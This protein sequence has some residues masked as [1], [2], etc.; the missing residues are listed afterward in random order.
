MKKLNS[1]NWDRIVRLLA[2][3]KHCILAVLCVPCVLHAQTTSDIEFQYLNI[4]QGLSDNWVTSIFMDS[5]GFMWIGTNNGLNRWDGVEIKVF[6]NNLVN[7]N[8]LVDNTINCIYED[9]QGRIWI[10]TID[11]INVFDWKTEKFS[12]FKSN[13]NDTASLGGKNVIKI[14]E[15][16][17]KNMWV[18]TTSG[19]DMFDEQSHTFIHF[20]NDP[21]DTNSLIDNYINDIEVDSKQNL[22]IATKNG[23]DYFNPKAKTFKHFR[24]IKGDRG[25][26]MPTITA[27]I[28][29]LSMN[30]AND[31]HIDN[32]GEVWVG[33]IYG[34]IYKLNKGTG[35]FEDVSFLRDEVVELSE[36]SVH[37]ITED[38]KGLL[39]LGTEKALYVS[40]PQK[41]NFKEL[42]SSIS[43]PG[44]FLGDAIKALY[45]DPRNGIIWVGTQNGGINYFNKENDAFLKYKVGEG[46]LSHRTIFSFVEDNEGN[47]WIATFGGGVNVL[48]KKTGLIKVYRHTSEKN[49][50]TSD[51]VIQVES[52]RD[53]NIWIGTFGEGVS[54]Y[55]KKSDGFINYL[56]NPNDPTN[57]RGTNVYDIYKDVKGNLWMGTEANEGLNLFDPVT[58]T[59]TAFS[60]I[61]VDPE[62]PRNDFI[63]QIYDYD[64]ENLVIVTFKSIQLFNK[65]THKFK[66]LFRELEEKADIIQ[67]VRMDKHGTL[68]VGTNSGLIAIDTLSRNYKILS[69][70]DGLPSNNIT[71][72]EEDNK[73][74]IW[75]STK[76]NGLFKLTTPLAES[77]HLNIVIFSKRDGL[78]SREF[79]SRSSYKGKDSMLYFGG[80]YGFNKFDPN[81]VSGNLKPPPIVITKF[82]LFNND[83][84]PKPDTKLE[85]S[86]TQTKKIVL[87]PKDY[88][89]SI[90]FASLNYLSPE[91]NQYKYKLENFDKDWNYAKGSNNVVTYTNLDAGT[92]TFVVKGSNNYGIWNETGTHLTIVVKP[93]YWKEWWFVTGVSIFF[94]MILI[95]YSVQKSAGIKKQRALLEETVKVRTLELEEANKVLTTQQTELKTQGEKMESLYNDVTDSIRAAETIQNI[96]LSGKS[97]LKR[98]LPKSFILNLPKD[99]VS[100]DFY[101]CEKIENKIVLA[102]ADCTGHGVSG[103]LMTVNGHYLLNQLKYGFNS[104]ADFLNKLNHLIFELE[105]KNKAEDMYAIGMDITV[106]ML[107]LVE[108]VLHYATAS[109]KIYIQ[110]NGEIIEFRGNS[111]SIGQLIQGEIPAFNDHKIALQKNDLVY[112]FTDGYPDQ[113]GG[114]NGDEKIKHFRFKNLLSSLSNIPI[115]EQETPVKDFL[116]QWKKDNEQMD[117]ILII[118][119]QVDPS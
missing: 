40:D 20:K 18:A 72:I 34:G 75:I 31:V 87:S 28:R 58:N 41:K 53:G 81:K 26:I 11:G 95:S 80:Q 48:N 115:M 96:I 110:R 27:S 6:Q 24:D 69:E 54:V 63:R 108:P 104:P 93:P 71:A 30:Y 2:W 100:G 1:Q 12:S 77:G 51:Q 90:G 22:W 29:E 78:Q 61:K 10:A 118:G 91:K 109:H 64:K 65:R 55:D 73:D 9:S 105:R 33:A 25:G 84:L 43:N 46:S 39:Y 116:L 85:R 47:L 8:V 88:I 60:H 66:R 113:F 19:L 74:G 17:E 44:S 92:Y 37:Y 94:I 62:S 3:A 111:F 89:F 82:R 98:D 23:V 106:C 13:K 70:K 16:K 103:A 38:S 42:A 86:I 57:L 59:F 79:V 99:I 112:F 83:L 52:D 67:C 50:L 76:T 119:F 35:E 68:W 7:P 21:Y 97:V 114:E 36:K 49:S 107:D 32:E 117:D 4:K 56:S 15:D 14:I 5:K 101:W 45:F 102:V